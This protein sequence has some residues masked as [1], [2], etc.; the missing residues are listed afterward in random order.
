MS[1]QDG[2]IL[3]ILAALT[4]HVLYLFVFSR[5]GIRAVAGLMVALISGLIANTITG[6]YVNTQLAN[7]LHI[8]LVV[9]SF[10]LGPLVEEGAKF[11]FLILLLVPM[12]RHAKSSS[13]RNLSF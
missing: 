10:T 7:S 13:E 6:G 9:Y 4:A 11:S 12:N 1:P 3:V 2:E 5:R 8:G